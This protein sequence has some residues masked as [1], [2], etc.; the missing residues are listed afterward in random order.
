MKIL[1]KLTSFQK[2]FFLLF[3][4]FVSFSLYQIFADSLSQIYKLKQNYALKKQSTVFIHD[5]SLLIFDIQK[6]RGLTNIYLNNKRLDNKLINIQH[7][8]LIRRLNYIIN[9][10]EYLNTNKQLSLIQSELL[11][12]KKNINI[13]SHQRI[14][15]KY[16]LLIDSLMS[17]VNITSYNN[18]LHKDVNVVGKILME[19]L[20]NEI[21]FT[22]ENFGNA[23]GITA[24]NL[25][26]NQ[27]TLTKISEISFYNKL[28]YLDMKKINIKLRNLVKFDN[29][30]SSDLKKN[31]KILEQSSYDFITLLNMQ[32][33][34]SK[35]NIDDAYHFYQL[36]TNIIDRHISVY[37]KLFTVFEKV[38]ENEYKNLTYKYITKT[39]IET[40]FLILAIIV[41]VL[42]YK[43]S[44]KYINRIKKAEKIK[45]DFLSNM[46]HEIRTP[47]NAIIG[48]IKLIKEKKDD[49]SDEY[50][51]IVENSS[52]QLLFIINDILDLTKIEKNKVKLEISDFNA[53]KEFQLI[54]ELFVANA[55]SKK[56]DLKFNIANTIP[57]FIKS[58][59]FRLKQIISNLLS[60]AIKF[61]PKNGEVILDI[62]MFKNKIRISISDNGMGIPKNKQKI[63]FNS[64]SQVDEAT[65]RKFG[66]T[67]LGLA[68][69]S[70][71]VKLF[72]SKLILKSEENKGSTF[73]FDI[74]LVKSDKKIE[75]N[76]IKI[77][78]RKYFGKILLVEDNP[79]NQFLMEVTFDNLSLDVIIANDG[80]EAIEI[81]KK[82]NFDLIFMD[83][84]MPNMNGIEASKKII[85]Y[86]KENNL[87][88][89]NIVAL[90][91]NAQK[92]DKNRFLN[93]G[94]NE[95]MAKPLDMDILYEVL[96]KYLK[97]R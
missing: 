78:S 83:E 70:K 45:S 60:N 48:F 89:T 40:I 18:D 85:E 96:D 39:L 11:F 92:N 55:L 76:E 65:T 22:I 81:F 54:K 82:H 94:M 73:Y 28:I 38:L 13:Y 84:N 67:G 90:T 10:Y 95:Y 19:L 21:P 97:Q 41:F 4:I 57:M 61:T 8:L 7:N 14:F 52:K 47:L 29:K 86:E 58:D 17:L 20:I 91:A 26:Q 71:L 31:I 87:K 6:T 50:L 53:K 42:F 24:G 49:K 30:F 62:S 32:N 63:I 23:R 51:D 33:I 46:S 15:Y 25:V 80:I 68:I 56:I 37:N 72:D 74:E 27:N 64:F 69:C 93:A 79:T 35:A 36:S 88:H 3:L 9:K 16:T 43:S 59:I 1:F 77:E 66:G 34:K 2:R 12:I 75:N 5:L 44:L